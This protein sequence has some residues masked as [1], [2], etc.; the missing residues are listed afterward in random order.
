MLSDSLVW[1]FQ[2]RLISWNFE[3]IHR[4]FWIRQTDPKTHPVGGNGLL[5][6]GEWPY[7]FELRKATITQRTTLHN[8]SEQNSISECTTLQTLKQMGYNRRKPLQIP[9]LSAKNRNQVYRNWSIQGWEKTRRCIPVEMAS[10]WKSFF[11]FNYR[12]KCGGPWYTHWH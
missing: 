11:F 6:S 7:W 10:E 1:L 3:I 9:F 2:K 8:H 12:T 4:M 5:M